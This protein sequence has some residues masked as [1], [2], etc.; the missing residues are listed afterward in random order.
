MSLGAP[1]HH[2]PVFAQR[3]RSG[4]N[5][6]F[7]PI[8]VVC[9]IGAAFDIILPRQWRLLP[10]PDGARKPFLDHVV[11]KAEALTAFAFLE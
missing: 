2:G 3:R 9:L 10:Q 11:D 4:F 5:R 1:S 7:T 8:L 6:L